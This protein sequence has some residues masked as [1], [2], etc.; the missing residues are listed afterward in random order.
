L[1]DFVPDSQAVRPQALEAEIHEKEALFT[2]AFLKGIYRRAY[3]VVRHREDA[4]DIAQ[5]ACLQLWKESKLGRRFEF[6]TAWMN[7]VMRNAAFGQFRKT[8]PDLHI[9][10]MAPDRFTSDEE[11][12]RIFDIPDPA[13]LVLDEIIEAKRLE[14]EE[15]LLHHVVLVL[16]DLPEIERDCVMMCAR[17]YSFVQIAKA[18]DLDYRATIRITRQV[19][20]EI[21]AK[22]EI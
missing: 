15:R 22:V 5:E 11:D 17:G 3:A 2:E 14:G 7:T 12:A 18:L 20:S 9:P 10:L 16:S 19:I 13:P 6:L 8:R 1:S 21:R 4:E